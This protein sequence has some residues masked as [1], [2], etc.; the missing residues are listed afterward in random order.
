MNEFVS[1]KSSSSS[2]GHLQ[3]ILHQSETLGDL[4]HLVIKSG[5]QQR[6]ILVLHIWLHFELQGP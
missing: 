6:E 1:F 5:R 3:L 4:R 2:L